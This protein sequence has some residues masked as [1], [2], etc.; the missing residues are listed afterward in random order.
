VELLVV[1]GIIVVLIGILVPTVS[2]VRTRAYAANTSA[3]IQLLSGSIQQY[4]NVFDA[5]PGCLDD[6]STQL[7]RGQNGPSGNQYTSSELLV[8]A[9]CGGAQ[10]DTTVG[11]VDRMIFVPADVGSGPITLYP[12][13]AKG[14]IKMPKRYPAFVDP[15]AGGVDPMRNPATNQ[16]YPWKDQHHSTGVMWFSFFSD[17]T[18]PEFVDRFPDAMP[19][20]Y[21]RAKPGASG[22]VF[23]TGGG[24]RGPLAAW[25]PPN[26]PAA[27][28]LS[29]L[30]PYQQF[31]DGA[32]NLW[33]TKP[34]AATTDP[35]YKEIK[36]PAYYFAEP[37][38]QNSVTVANLVARQKSGYMLISAGIDR[39][40]DTAD[41]IT[42]AGPPK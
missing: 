17:S 15:G 5:Y 2:K 24:G 25:A 10:F 26:L 1:I 35:T 18:A 27:Y 23:R 6:G 36:D 3:Q 13:P 28:D 8:M 41:D 34:G 14:G 9:L 21:I 33:P 30:R 37:V 11:G 7:L 29:M 4:R 16:W 40:Y 19:I 20:L 31:P 22:T 42:N 12:P 32:P 39:I 38:D